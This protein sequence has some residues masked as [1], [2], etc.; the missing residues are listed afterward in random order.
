MKKNQEIS[1]VYKKNYTFVCMFDALNLLDH[2]SDY[3]IMT[4]TR[5]IYCLLLYVWYQ[6]NRGKSFFLET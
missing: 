1:T 2:W 4:I 5:D 3:H 6:F